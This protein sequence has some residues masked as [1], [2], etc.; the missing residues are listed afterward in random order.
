MNFRGGCFTKNDNSDFEAFRWN[1]LI[2][3][4]LLAGLMLARTMHVF[5]LILFVLFCFPCYCIS[6]TCLCKK[7]FAIKGSGTSNIILEWLR[8]QK[9]EYNR[10][11]DFEDFALIF[12]LKAESKKNGSVE[13]FEVVKKSSYFADGKTE[14][15]CQLCS[16]SFEKNE[17]I[18]FLPCSKALNS[19]SEQNVF[20]IDLHHFFHYE[21]LETYLKKRQRCPTCQVVVAPFIIK[22]ADETNFEL[23]RKF[24]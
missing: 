17:E 3:I 23:R 4:Y 9:W 22:N 15:N 18:V 5:Q 6:D 14:T 1:L 8:T 19:T 24:A 2:P 11:K 7:K 21:C 13:N 20:G 10:V 12:K 16:F